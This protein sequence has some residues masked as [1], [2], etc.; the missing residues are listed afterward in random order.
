VRAA[1]SPRD[2]GL[3]VPAAFVLLTFALFVALGTWQVERKG[4]K[5]ALI[6]ILGERLS[7]PPQALPP[8]ASWD[9]LTAA[10]AEFR[11]V[12]FRAEFLKPDPPNPRNEEARVYSNGSALR[13]DIKGPGY[14][15]FAP[16]RLADGRIVVVN[17]GFVAGPPDV[18]TRPIPHPEGPVDIVGVL[19]WP[20]TRGWFVPG[21]D[22]RN[23]LW[24]A[25]SLSEMTSQKEWNTT[26]PFYVE[27]EAPVPV[28]GVPKP[29]RLSINLPNNHLQYAV[30]WYGLA[31]VLVAVFG[32]WVRSRSNSSARAA[33]L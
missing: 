20:E 10:E 13:E 4:W 22:A 17:R 28:G 24:Y 9:L 2:R 26:A 27:Q 1:A 23:D 7:A 19:R 30:T 31:A 18:R 3:L 8:S 16:A 5:E 14:F 29:G 6:A 11:R 15:V 33:S 21:Y 32:F 25:R 12:A